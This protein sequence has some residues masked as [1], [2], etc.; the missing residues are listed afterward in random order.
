MSKYIYKA[1]WSWTNQRRWFGRW[2]AYSGPIPLSGLK[3]SIPSYD[4]GSYVMVVALCIAHLIQSATPALGCTGWGWVSGS[5]TNWQ[6]CGLAPSY[7][8]NDLQ[9]VADLDARR[10]LRSASTSTPVVPVT[11]L[12]TVGDRAFPV[13]A[14]RVWN[15][16]PADVTLSPSL[17][18]FK[19]RLKTELFVWSYP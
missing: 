1:P 10:C 5:I 18:T 17:S 13:A 9:C 11:R 19:R 14:V 8:G 7:L 4:C 2:W 16:L 3:S 12:S 6:F 15:S